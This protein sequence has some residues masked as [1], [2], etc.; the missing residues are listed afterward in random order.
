MSVINIALI[1]FG[2]L[3]GGYYMETTKHYC[4][5][6]DKKFSTGSI[7][8]SKICK[9]ENKYNEII[10]KYE[11]VAVWTDLPA[12]GAKIIEPLSSL[13]KDKERSSSS[14]RVPPPPEDRTPSGIGLN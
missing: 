2:C 10:N 14:P 4:V 7:Y 12:E 3:V 8:K 1:V 9:F 6:E 5:Y 11:T 13:P